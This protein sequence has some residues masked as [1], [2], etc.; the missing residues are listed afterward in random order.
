MKPLI[1]ESTHVMVTPLKVGTAQPRGAQPLPPG[2]HVLHMYT[3]LKM[4]SSKVF[5]VVRNMSEPLV[6][7]ACR[8]TGMQVVR[9][10]SVLPVETAELSPEMEVVL[11]SE[12][13]Q[14]PL[15]VSEWQGKLLEKLDLNVLSH[16][17]PRN[18][19]AAQ[20]LVLSF[21]DVFALDGHRLGCTMDS[22]PFK[23]H[24]RWIPPLLLEEVCASLSDMLDAGAMS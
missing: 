14:Q 4:S 16:W 2:L 6:F 13:K 11:G 15:S 9:V 10:V 12:D 23:E 1:G 24:F 21:H 3:R 19:A 5:V 22:E 7:L 18:A 8:K 20:E 17:T